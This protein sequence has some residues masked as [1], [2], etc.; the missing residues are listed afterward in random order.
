MLNTAF[1]FHGQGQLAKLKRIT[2]LRILYRICMNTMLRSVFIDMHHCYNKEVV[3]VGIHLNFYY[4]HV[5]FISCLFLLV[6]TA[7]GIL[8]RHTSISMFIHSFSHNQ[9]SWN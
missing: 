9:I 2:N 7:G 8:H 1:S 4:I 6:L 3:S 5:S